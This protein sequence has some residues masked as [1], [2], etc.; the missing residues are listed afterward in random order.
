MS[1][2][3]KQVDTK[4]EFPPFCTTRIH[5][6]NSHFLETLQKETANICI[7]SLRQL[8][9]KFICKYERR[10]DNCQKHLVK[11]S[12]VNSK[13]EKNSHVASNSSPFIVASPG[14]KLT[15]VTGSLSDLVSSSARW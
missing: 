7:L 15:D 3:T 5:A 9:P 12:Y 11:K 13:N 8:Q 14:A 2:N 4:G 1:I 10:W 6:H